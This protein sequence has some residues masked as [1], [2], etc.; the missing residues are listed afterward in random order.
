MRSITRALRF[1]LCLIAQFASRQGDDLYAYATHGRTLRDAIL[2][3]G[4]AAA[5]PT[6]VMAYTH[7]PQHGSLGAGDFAASA[8]YVARFGTAGFPPDVAASLT[9]DTWQTRIGGDTLLFIPR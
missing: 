4:K 3:L 7:D 2:F 9:H 8:F 1:S 6:L 5:D